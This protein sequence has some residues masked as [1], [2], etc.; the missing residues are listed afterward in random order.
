MVIRRNPSLAKLCSSLLLATAGSMSLL[1]FP[2]EAM[3]QSITTGLLDEEVEQS[4]N[5]VTM[6]QP[7]WE[8]SVGQ[9][10][11]RSSEPKPVALNDLL[12]SA[13]DHS[14]QIKVFSDIPLIRETSI[15]ESQ[16][17][18]DWHA[19]AEASLGSASHPVGS[20][21]D[22]GIPG[23]DRLIQDQLS[24]AAGLRKQTVTGG[25]FE[26][27]QQIGMFD[28][29]S[30][31]L[32]PQNQG[33]GK[34]ALSFT[35]PLLNGAG[36]PYNTSMILLSE[37]DSNIAQDE[38]ARQL[39]SHLL[40]ITRAYWTLHL[41]RTLL[42]LKQNLY[43]QGVKVQQSLQAREGIDVVQS[44]I[45]LVEAAVAERKS[46][47]IRAA[48]AV[49][50]SEARIRALVNDPALNRTGLEFIPTD[51]PTQTYLPMNLQ[52]V[53]TE[54]ISQRPEV[55]Q[56]IKQVHAA[57]IRL[58]MSKNE[59]LP[60]LNA[61]FD[62]YA[63]GLR[64]NYNIG[65]A[66]GDQFD[67]GRPSV[68]G[69]LLYDIPIGNRQA[70]GRYSRRE[71]ELRQ[72]QNQLSTTIATLSLESEVAL[73]EVETSFAE[74][75]LK[76]KSMK[77]AVA[78]VTALKTRWDML[79]GEDQAGSLYLQNLLDAQARATAAEAQFAQA[80]LTYSLSL[81]NLKKA[82][83]TLLKYEMISQ[84]RRE[85]GSIPE[86]VLEKS[87]NPTL[88]EQPL[89]DDPEAENTEETTPIPE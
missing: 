15:I 80:R 17:R 84:M 40:E 47:L 79:P 31:F 86:I 51:I 8:K 2:G 59:L 50:N 18:F 53:L 32:V 49:R 76:Y 88:Q 60:Q 42:I 82:T 67:S 87:G 35:Q 69:G 72:M 30:R 36:R 16:G 65:T 83:G 45:V 56:N 6:T 12:I 48:A 71:I 5:L 52:D 73:R 37:I 61:V 41:E 13:L 24:A 74:M 57:G 28:N 4:T 3:A 29:N 19:F 25:T 78:R 39:Q 63:E 38:F 1:A 70:R 44:Q 55:Q 11:S 34:L 14:T 7:W 54:T 89:P 66:L 9:S 21:L 77:A 27:R 10:I 22:T 23:Q 85:D 75:L 58:N 68:N 64:G 62:V 20:S 33:T 26:I 43:R 81:M 46:E